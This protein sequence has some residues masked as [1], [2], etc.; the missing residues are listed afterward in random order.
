MPPLSLARHSTAEHKRE[1]SQAPEEY[2]DG[3]EK[4]KEKEDEEVEEE[5]WS[6]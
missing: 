3:E 2:E 6:A 5:R 1:D 4:E